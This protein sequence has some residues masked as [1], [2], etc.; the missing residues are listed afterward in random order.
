MLTFVVAVDCAAICKDAGSLLVW[1]RFG[2][3]TLLCGNFGSADPSSKWPWASRCC[4]NNEFCMKRSP[5]MHWYG[6]SPVWRRM[7]SVR[8]LASVKSRSQNVHLYGFSPA[9]TLKVEVELDVHD[10]KCRMHRVEC[11][12]HMTGQFIWSGERTAAES[13]WIWLFACM[14][15]PMAY[16]VRVPGKCY[17]EQWNSDD[18]SWDDQPIQKLHTF[19]A[20]VALEWAFACMTAHV[21]SQT[22]WTCQTN[23]TVNA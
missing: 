18:I 8:S 21:H 11:L 6:R 2:L 1:K 13:A 3:F 15:T 19:V 20:E 5:Q 14:R 23:S 12:P 4:F 17:N 10:H 7:C 22:G 16:H 9:C